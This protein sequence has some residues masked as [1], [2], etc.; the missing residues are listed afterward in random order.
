MDILTALA[1]PVRRTILEELHKRP[2]TAGQVAKRFPISRPAVS[3]HL[4][5]LREAGLVS[6][7]Q[8]GRERIYRVEPARLAELDAWL[9]QFRD[10]WASRFDA[11]ET[12]VHRTRRERERRKQSN[13]QVRTSTR[14]RAIDTHDIDTKEQPA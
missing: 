9:A 2:L 10:T 11:L 5:V 12:E 13:A 4:R 8:S 14:D 1:D 7:S 6:V 3:R